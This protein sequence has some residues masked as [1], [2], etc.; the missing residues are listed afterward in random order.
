MVGFIEKFGGVL[1]KLGTAMKPFVDLTSGKNVNI[2]GVQLAI[3]KR[4]EEKVVSVV[5][6]KKE[7][8]IILWVIGGVVF[9]ILLVLVIVL[10]KK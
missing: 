9:F 2:G 3:K 1:E 4:E 6:E 7:S 10:I 5:E 8:N